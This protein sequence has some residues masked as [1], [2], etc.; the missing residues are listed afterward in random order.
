M[1]TKNIIIILFFVFPLLLS[2]KIQWLTPSI[3]KYGNIQEGEK[4]TDTIKFINLGETPVEIQSVRPSCGCTVTSLTQRIIA[5]HD[6]AYIPFSLNTMGFSGMIRKSINISFKENKEDDAQFILQANIIRDLEIAPR[7][8]YITRLKVDQDTT[9]TRTIT[10]INNSEQA[11][12][13][14]NMITE[15][16]LIE[17]PKTSFKLIAGQS[18]DIDIKIFP[19]RVIH[20]RQFITINTSMPNKPHINISVYMVIKE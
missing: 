16:D 3:I 8:I 15:S 6:T 17:L 18:K 13:I 4:I 14:N 12:E 2:A 10:F 9:L 11:I 7:Y 5:S 19:R 20:G 1:N